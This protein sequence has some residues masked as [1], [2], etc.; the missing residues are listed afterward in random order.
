MKIPLHHNRRD[1]PWTD[2]AT[3]KI[4]LWSTM[5]SI[6]PA[7]FRQFRTSKARGKPP[8]TR[9]E[10]ISDLEAKLA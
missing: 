5:A 8:K 9:L 7:G 4:D 1:K 2:R 10:H 3:E 6:N